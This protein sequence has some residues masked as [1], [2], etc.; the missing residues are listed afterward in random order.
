VSRFVSRAGRLAYHDRRR[1][2]LAKI[3]ADTPGLAAKI[4]SI[5]TA[6]STD[7]QD[8][9]AVMARSMALL[10]AGK[11]PKPVVTGRIVERFGQKMDFR[12][13][14]KGRPADM[15]LVPIPDKSRWKV[16]TTANDGGTPLQIVCG[17]LELS[18][19]KWCLQWIALSKKLKR[20][21]E[22]P[23]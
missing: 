11:F 2:G 20:A 17:A 7:V 19:S 15:L 1:P 10:V 9:E 8:E 6:I 16:V 3:L 21:C 22:D 4:D 18:T 13:W 5:A 23:E 14:E 12:R